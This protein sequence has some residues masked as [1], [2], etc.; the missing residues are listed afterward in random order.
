M[1]TAQA[2]TGSGGADEEDKPDDEP[3]FHRRS[4]RIDTVG[5]K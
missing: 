1:A 5:R 2:V 4:G 3:V